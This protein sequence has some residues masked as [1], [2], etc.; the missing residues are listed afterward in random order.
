M[1]LW[2]VYIILVIWRALESIK[3]GKKVKVLCI[4]ARNHER[5]EVVLHQYLKVVK[6][7]SKTIDF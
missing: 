4:V 5:S 3:E 7:G 1:D 2:M 6:L